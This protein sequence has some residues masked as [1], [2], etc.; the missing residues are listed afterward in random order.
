MSLNLLG[1]H[2]NP[3]DDHNDH[4][5]SSSRVSWLTNVVFV[6]SLK[7][8]L[9]NWCWTLFLFSV[10]ELASSLFI[11]PRLNFMLPLYLGR[12]GTLS[13]FFKHWLCQHGNYRTLQR[14]IILG[15]EFSAVVNFFFVMHSTSGLCSGQQ[16]PKN[17]SNPVES[18]AQTLLSKDFLTWHML[19]CNVYR[20][21]SHR[22]ASGQL[23]PLGVGTKGKT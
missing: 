12:Q 13:P 4:H 6:S 18:T 1:F 21:I 22:V 5:L 11:T 19:S 23:L 2:F 9:A 15:D 8:P 17:W 20:I 3:S 16:H 10:L 14:A 7:I